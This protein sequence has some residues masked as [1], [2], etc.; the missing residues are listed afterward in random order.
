MK[1]D[2][3]KMIEMAKKTMAHAYVPFCHFPVGACIRTVE[4]HLFAG[5]NWE[6]A[7]APLS[8]CAEGSAISAMIS[9]GYRMIS[10]VV[11]IAE[12]IDICTPCGGCRQ[13]LL[14]FSDRE[15]KIYACDKEGHLKKVFSMEILLPS[16]FTR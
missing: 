12:K 9:S 16:A 2:L 5:C 14:E 6:N 11:I 15:T 4:G 10:A 8:Q 1:N 7:S 3:D 13:R